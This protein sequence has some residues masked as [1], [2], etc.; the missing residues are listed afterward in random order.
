MTDESQRRQ[1][2]AE[3]KD[4]DFKQGVVAFEAF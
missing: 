2:G 1:N 3:T 4:G